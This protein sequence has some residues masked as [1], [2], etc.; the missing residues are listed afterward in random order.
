MGLIT[1]STTLDGAVGFSSSIPYAYSDTNGVPA[2]K[3]DLYGVVAH[4]ISE[5]MG[6]ISLL[7][8]NEAYS[9]MDLFRYAANGVPSFTRA[10]CI[11]FGQRR[12]H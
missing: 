9:V 4:E 10:R 6:R 8:Y 1:G 2:G 3:Y 7:N 12:K 5:V 11:F